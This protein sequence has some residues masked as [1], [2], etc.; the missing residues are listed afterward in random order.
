[1]QQIRYFHLSPKGKDHDTNVKTFMPDNATPEEIWD[2]GRKLMAQ[3]WS[4]PVDCWVKCEPEEDEVIKKHKTGLIVTV[5]DGLY[6]NAVGRI[7]N[8]E[9][10]RINSPD[11]VVIYLQDEHTRKHGVRI[12]GVSE[13]DCKI[14]G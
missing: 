7:I 3:H 14:L 6:K 5:T 13:K 4:D 11:D 12:I 2:E 9:S 1:M 8:Q 10:P